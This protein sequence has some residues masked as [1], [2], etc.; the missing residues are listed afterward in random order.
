MS[1]N[2]GLIVALQKFD[3]LKLKYIYIFPKGGASRATETIC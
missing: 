2:C 3:V 1:R